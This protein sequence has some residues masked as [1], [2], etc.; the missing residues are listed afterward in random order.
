[1]ENKP[2]T[3][4]D[5]PCKEKKQDTK[6]IENNSL[7][8]S[9]L[10][11]AEY[12]H[13]YQTYMEL[14]T[15]EAKDALDHAFRKYYAELRLIRTLSNTLKRH[16]I[17]YDQKRNRQSERQLLILDQPVSYVTDSETTNLDLIQDTT[18]IAIDETVLEKEDSLENIIENPTLYDAIRSLT[19]RQVYILESYYLRGMTDT[20]IAKKDGVSQQSISKTRNKALSKLRKH[21]LE[22]KGD[23]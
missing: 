17:R 5:S 13:L 4:S 21:L 11:N 22:Q 9:F 1:M 20:E 16:A 6:K 15:K 14:K 12:H 8:Q 19:P 2:T 18:A 3:T 10:Q 23:E 7:I